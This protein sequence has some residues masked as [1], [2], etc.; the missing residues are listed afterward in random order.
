MNSQHW[1]NVQPEWEANLH[2]FLSCRQKHMQR[3]TI[4]FLQNFIPPDISFVSFA[5]G[6]TV[7]NMIYS[8]SDCTDMGLEHPAYAIR[9]CE[10]RFVGIIY[11]EGIFNNLISLF[12]PFCF[13]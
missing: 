10:S 7:S 6:L 1:V 9:G 4:F 5:V 3:D 13:I 2:D 12:L 11:S 8:V